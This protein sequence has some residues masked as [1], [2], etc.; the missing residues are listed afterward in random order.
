[1]PLCRSAAE[2]GWKVRLIDH[3]PAFARSDRFPSAASIVVSQPGSVA[4]VLCSGSADAVVVMSHHFERD[5]EYLAAALS[6]GAPYVGV[7]GPRTRRD[8][9]LAELAATRPEVSLASLDPLYAPIGLDLGA[10]TPEE[11][12][13]AIVSEL[14]AVQR[15]RSGGS[16]RERRAGIHESA[17]AAT[18]RLQSE[19]TVARRRAG[20]RRAVKEI[21]P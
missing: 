9:L 20:V 18:R 21:G 3:R 11:I 15:G 6:S 14:M 16:L 10:D 4:A 2:L 8:R 7:L 13:L 5:V 17:T 1:M 12:A 19:S